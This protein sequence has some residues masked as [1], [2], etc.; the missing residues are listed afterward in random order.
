MCF[1]K[2]K[3]QVELTPTQKMEKMLKEDGSFSGFTVEAFDECQFNVYGNPEYL[4]VMG[5]NST[6]GV[7]YQE[8]K[9]EMIVCP[10]AGSMAQ[11]EVEDMLRSLSFEKGIKV[12][13]SVD[14]R[15]GLEI[16]FEIDRTISDD[17]LE[18][19]IHLLSN[20][21]IRFLTLAMQQVQ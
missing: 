7:F 18:E 1:F 8:H 14:D 5:E 9:L 6:I 20:A 12:E 21:I 13:S 2:K 3:K 16:S 17:E 11:T 4:K 10:E 19:S 15:F